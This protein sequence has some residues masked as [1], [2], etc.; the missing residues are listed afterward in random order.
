[1]TIGLSGPPVRGALSDNVT[2]S[3]G[4][5]SPHCGGLKRT[6][7]RPQTPALG[8]RDHAGLGLISKSRKPRTIISV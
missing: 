4:R 3:G 8:P 7:H 6:S 2:A 1:M 5:E